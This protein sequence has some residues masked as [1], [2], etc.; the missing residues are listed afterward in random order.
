M[1]EAYSDGGG[2]NLKKCDFYCSFKIGDELHSR[3]PI[4]VRST[5]EA[6]YQ[7][8]ILLLED[9]Y[10]TDCKEDV[11]I[12][13]DSRLVVQQVNGKWRVSS[14]NLIPFYLKA[15]GLIESIQTNQHISIHLEWWGRKNSVRELG[16]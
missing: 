12:R 11:I 7:A 15:I 3:I 9:I 1:I 2:N 8:L 10:L 16:H 14:K 5:N 6:E 4:N 13:S